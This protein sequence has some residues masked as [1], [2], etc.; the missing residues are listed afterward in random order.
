MDIVERVIEIIT[1][2]VE[3]LGFELVRVTYGGDEHVKLQIMAERPDGSMSIEGCELLS[4]DISAILDV[5]DPIRGD[6]VLEVSSPGLDRPLTRRKDFDR[7]KG[8]EAK[9]T[10]GQQIEGRRRFSGLL[11]GIDDEDMVHIETQEGPAA[12]PFDMIDKAK[13]ILTDALLAAHKT[14]NAK[15]EH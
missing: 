9:V 15:Q 4:R 8:F 12:I 7:Y 5:E 6:Y 14:A 10:A 2:A 11:T 3:D 1:P 13:L